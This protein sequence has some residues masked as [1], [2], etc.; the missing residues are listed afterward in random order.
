MK[1]HDKKL[2]EAKKRLDA[3]MA[4]IRKRQK[5]NEAIS[6]EEPLGLLSACWDEVGHA[7]ELQEQEQELKQEKK[8]K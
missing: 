2:E 8:E 7:R 6:I 3:G 1:N 4:T 5:I